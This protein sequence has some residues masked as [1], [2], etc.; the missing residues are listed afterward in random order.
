M[1]VLDFVTC[2]SILPEDSTPVPKYVGVDA[3]QELYIDVCILLYFTE[4]VFWV[5][6]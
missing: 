3:Y 2:F 1:L 6:Y 5:I 4:C